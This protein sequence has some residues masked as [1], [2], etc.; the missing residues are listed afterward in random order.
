MNK[1]P[2][3]R[4][5]LTDMDGTLLNSRKE[6]PKETDA[7][8]QQCLERGIL[9]GCASGRQLINL[10]RYFEKWKDSLFFIGE[11]GA[12]A[13]YGQKV[14]HY[15]A[16]DK[17][18]I[19]E[20]LQRARALKTAWP[21]FCTKDCAYIESED[22]RLLQ[23]CR[24]YYAE[25]KVVASL[26]S[27]TEPPCKISICDL[28]GSEAQAWPAFQSLQDQVQITVSAD[29]WLDIC[30][31]GECKG[32]A[33]AL[34]QH[35]MGILPETTMVFGDYLNDASLMP[36]AAYSYAMANAHPDLAKLARFR[37]PSNEEGGVITVIQQYLNS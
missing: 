27:L 34:F 22:P 20:L 7:V 19:P 33:A 37:A 18:L 9:F 1:Q 14:I 16:L 10:Q 21:V 35:Q 28:T 2:A 24:K 30:N 26:D 13:R 4:L 3:I 25:L 29:I 8:I 11:N 23:E 15:S 31:L 36:L 6:L 17:A 12:Y 32:K 5:I